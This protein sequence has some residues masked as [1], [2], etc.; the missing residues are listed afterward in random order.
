MMIDTAYFHAYRAAADVDT[1]AV[2]GVYPDMLT[3][4]RVRARSTRRRQRGWRSPP[5]RMCAFH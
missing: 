2:R 5:E 3:R 1:A 4:A